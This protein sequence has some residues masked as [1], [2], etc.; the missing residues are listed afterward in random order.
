M[1]DYNVNLVRRLV[2]KRGPPVVTLGD[3]VRLIGDLPEFPSLRPAWQIACE[4]I[5]RAATTL[6]P[7]DIES[8]SVE[9]EIACRGDLLVDDH[10]PSPGGPPFDPT[11]SK[12]DRK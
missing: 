6:Q 12:S 4:A 9:V 8:A 3:A 7:A 2:L 10:R 11:P 1:A 5:L